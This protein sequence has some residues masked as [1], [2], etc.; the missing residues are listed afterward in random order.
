M[1]LLD[2]LSWSLL[3]R[4]HLKKTG[5]S[6]HWL[7]YVDKKTELFGANKLA[8]GTRLHGVHL[9]YATYVAGSVLVDCK[10]G[11]FCSIGPECLIGGL[12][13]H[14][15]NWLSTHPSFYST[16][17]QSGAVHAKAQHFQDAAPVQIGSDVWIGAR[18]MVLDGISV[19]HG[20]VI[21]AGSVVVRDVPSYAIVAGVPA[22][23]IRYRFSPE[24]IDR[25]L[26][27]RWWSLPPNKLSELSEL[28]VGELSLSQLDK[29]ESIL[30]SDFQG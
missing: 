29:V 5:S 7:T 2:R 22:K 4:R 12:S 21:A 18:V 20:A 10:V 19:G 11:A 17:G 15:T 9:G 8:K 6:A 26:S 13:S 23:V 16:R 24:I 14:P 3:R 30:V 25:L 1:G 28:W 27:L